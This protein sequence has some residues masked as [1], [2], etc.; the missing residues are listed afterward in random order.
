MRNAKKAAFFV[1][2]EMKFN[3]LGSTNVSAS[4]KTLRERLTASG[5]TNLHFNSPFFT[6]FTIYYVFTIFTGLVD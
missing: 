5:L 1:E 2:V 6:I 3:H 4:D